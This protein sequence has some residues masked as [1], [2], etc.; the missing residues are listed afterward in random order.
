MAYQVR[1][2]PALKR[3]PRVRGLAAAPCRRLACIHQASRNG[4]A[5]TGKRSVR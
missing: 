3:T 5:E 1:P 2:D 4:A